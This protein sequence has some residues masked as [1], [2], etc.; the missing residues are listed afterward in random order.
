[1]ASGLKQLSVIKVPLI[2]I[3]IFFIFVIFVIFV[4]FMLS[5]GCHHQPLAQL[6]LT[7]WPSLRSFP[8]HDGLGALRGFVFDTELLFQVTDPERQH[9]F[10]DILYILRSDVP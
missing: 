7:D 5:H 9:Q 8:L 10:L 2:S 4:A 3:F 1:M 6:P